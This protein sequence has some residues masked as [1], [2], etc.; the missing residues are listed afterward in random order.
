MAKRAA[1][2]EDRRLPCAN[3]LREDDLSYWDVAYKAGVSATTVAN[4]LLHGQRNRK[5]LVAIRNL[6]ADHKL[7][8][9]E[10]FGVRS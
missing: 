9:D 6:L 8:D 2:K 4:T 1:K 3:L 10:L 5:V 7:S